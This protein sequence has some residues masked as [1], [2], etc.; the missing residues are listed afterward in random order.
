MSYLSKHPE[1]E[2]YAGQEKEDGQCVP[3]K[4]A[5]R[6]WVGARAPQDQDAL[7]A[8]AGPIGIPSV[9]Y[10]KNCFSEMD[11]GDFS[12]PFA[13]GEQ[14]SRSRQP[15]SSF[16]TDEDMGSMCEDEVFDEPTGMAMSPPE[17]YEVGLSQEFTPHLLGSCGL[18]AIV[19]DFEMGMNTDLTD[20]TL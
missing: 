16:M 18:E 6:T 19:A 20:F 10:K 17:E 12:D 3:C 15:G 4:S 14:L 7:V 9:K 8:Q 2:V 1:C 13:L 11:L 5:E